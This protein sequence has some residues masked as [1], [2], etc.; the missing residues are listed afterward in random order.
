[1]TS[2]ADPA[3]R[4]PAPGSAPGKVIDAM[5]AEYETLREES[6][7]SI[8]HRLTVV[9]FTFAILGVVISGLLTGKVS[10]AVAGLIAILFLPQ[11]AKA[12]LWMW[13]G[14]YQRSRRAGKAIAELERK[15][16]VAVA[17][18]AL[19]W[20]SKLWDAESKAQ[21]TKVRHMNYP[22]AAVIVFLLGASYT[23]TALGIYL[24][25]SP[26]KR[27]WG[28][29]VANDLA[30]GISLLALVIEAAFAVDFHRRWKSSRA[31]A[32][33]APHP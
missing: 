6:L 13:L 18:E 31:E 16:N 4:E 28:A 1:M 12:A 2:N 25:Y 29:D 8:G 9:T 27:R 5:L 14:E 20:E 26:T 24:L 33:L 17:A 19:S 32:T 15:I 7:Q 23:A 22:Y 10:D 11:V 3:Q 21:R 30:I